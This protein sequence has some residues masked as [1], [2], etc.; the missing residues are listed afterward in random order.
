MTAC[1]SRPGVGGRSS[2]TKSVIRIA[3]VLLLA[4]P[5]AALGAIPAAERQALTN[6]Y[7]S[8]GG[9]AWTSNANW[10][11]GACPASGVPA[12]NAA[13]SEC[14]WYGV[15]CDGA[16]AHVIAI[17]LPGNNLA[18]TLPSL[19]ALAGL[20]YFSVASNRLGGSLPALA[21]LSHLQ[22]FYAG[23][24]AFTGALPALSG[25]TS[26]GDFAVPRNQLTGSIPS[27]SGLAALYSFNVAGNRLTGNVPALAGLANLRDFDASDNQLSGT[28]GTPSAAS[29]LLRLALERNNLSGTIAALPTGL[30]SAQL[31]FNRLSGAVPA[32]P[33]TLYTP[34][35]FASSTLCPNPLNTSASANDAGW[36]AATGFSPWWANPFATNRCD[37]L[38]ADGFD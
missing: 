26:L 22:S 4:L 36:N 6:L 1:A 18:G 24:N 10:C 16:Q 38:Q 7:T 21:S 8:A 14:T 19:N 12:F 15:T 28:I 11:S 2:A 29:A 33:A 13:G 3:A 17:A 25:L 31:G 9:G 5:I 32:A 20:E 27:L 37:D 34:A 23:D 30:Y 35:A